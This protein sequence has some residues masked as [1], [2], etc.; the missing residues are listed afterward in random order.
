LETSFTG[1]VHAKPSAGCTHGGRY[2]I[3]SYVEQSPLKEKLPTQRWD[4]VAPYDN[5]PFHK[6]AAVRGIKEI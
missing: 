1:D 6:R 4:F 5:F 2:G 3:G